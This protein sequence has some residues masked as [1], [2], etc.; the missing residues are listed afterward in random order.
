M[1]KKLTQISVEKMKPD[2]TKR[3]EYPDRDCP[4]L[5]LVVQPTGRKS[6]AVR[7][8]VRGRPGKLTLD[9]FPSLKLARERA[10]TALNEV[11]NGRDPAAEKRATKQAEVDARKDV[12]EEV[13]RRFINKYAKRETPRTWKQTASRLGFNPH[14]LTVK[15]GVAKR[16]G[17][18]PIGEIKKRDVIELN[19]SVLERAPVMATNVFAAV[20]RVFNWA[21]AVDI[22]A[23]SPC[24]GMAAPHAVQSRDR[25]LDDDEIRRLWNAGGE[26]GY[27]FGHIAK[28]LL[29]TGQRRDEVAG[30]RW[31]EIDLDERLWTIP[32]ERAKNDNTH[33]VPLSDAALDILREVKEIPR[34]FREKGLLFTTTGETAVSGFSKAKCQLD[35]LMGETSPWRLHDIRRTVATKMQA[36]HIPL[37]VTENVLNHVSGSRAGIVGI[38]QRHKYAEEKRTALDAWAE[39][40]VSL[41]AQ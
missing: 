12:F 17:K 39:H 21:V 13:A 30:M 41:V 34:A 24:Q 31:S 29:V 18:R 11:S 38:Y 40:I 37:E 8:R 32:K 27:P 14:D 33:D 36:L 5:Y 28:L 16:W 26:L 19:E 6:W 3:V 10:R 20:R 7:Y 9:G 4:G 23:T 35:D 1:L 2:P 22:I 15:G 25:V